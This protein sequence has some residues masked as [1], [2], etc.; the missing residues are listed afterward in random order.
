M[1]SILIFFKKQTRLMVV[2][3]INGKL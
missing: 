1:S 2:Q 3:K